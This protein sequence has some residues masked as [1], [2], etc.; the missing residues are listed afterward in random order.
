MTTESIARQK[1]LKD[2]RHVRHAEGRGSDTSDY[3]R[4]L[5]QCPATDPNSW[6]WA[7]RAKT[8]SYFVKNVLQ[9]LETSAGRQLDVLDLG[10]GNC[11]LSHR[12]SERAH[13]VVAVDIFDDERDGLA[14]ARHY[15][16][17]FRI[18][19]ADFDNLPL[20]ANSFDLAIFNA[21]FHYSVNYSRTL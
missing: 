7:I 12:L 13:R 21:S 3:Y 19:E 16:R 14:A 9:P 17:P 8:F 4:A 18:L 2:Y 1:F 11:W 15:V 10:A 20:P 6:M 5:P